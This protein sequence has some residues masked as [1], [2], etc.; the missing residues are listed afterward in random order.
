MEP[1]PAYAS[2]ILD[3]AIDK[4]LDYGIPNDLLLTIKQGSRVAVPLRGKIQ[5]GYVLDLKNK[6]DFLNVKPI[7]H[8]LS[9]TPLIPPDLFQ[10]ALWVSRY[11]CSPLRDV[12]RII[13]PPGVRKGMDPKEQ[14]YVMRAKTREEL[15]EICLSI[16]EKSPAQATIL[17]ALLPIKKGILLSKLLET[18]KCSR[19]SVDAL[20]KKGYL[21]LDIVRI[22]RSPLINE[23]Y[24]STKPKILNPQQAE[25]LKK[26][27][28]SIQQSVYETH[29]L[30]GITGSGK[31]EVYLQAI[32]RAL[33]ENKGTIML[34]PEIS[35]TSQTI[36][37]FKS[38]FQE[39][40]AIL[41]H[42][43][44]Q[45]ERN[46]EWHHIRSGKA[47]IVIGARSAIFSPV[48][49]LGLII[50]D[51]EHE[52]SY[53]QSEQNPC[54]QARDTAVMRGK[55]TKSTV[56]LGSATPSLESYYN[57]L[58]RKYTLSLLN[59]RAEV[60]SLPHV[61]V[62]DMKKEYEKAK[63][64]T[65]FSELLLNGI[66]KRIQKGEQTILFLNRRGYHSVLLCQD[67]QH[68]FKCQHCDLPLTFHL[69]DNCL[70][71][72]LC[73]FQ[74][75]PPPKSCPE[76]RGDKPL[77]FRGIGTEQV[78]RALHAIFPAV[79]TIR[80]DADT[81]KHKG[82][83]H[84]LLKDFGTGKAD[85]LIGTQMIA[86]GLHFSEVTLVGVLNS[87]SGLNI[88]DFR[89]SETVFQLITQVAGRSGRGSIPGEVIIQTGIPDHPTIQY[90]A[91]QDY[92]GFY[93]EEIGVRKIFN[94]P[95][96]SHLA[97]I[98]FSGKDAKQTQNVAEHFRQALVRCLPQN[99][100]FQP[101]VPCGYAKMKDNHRFQFLLKG[102]SMI[103]LNEALKKVEMNTVI[104]RVVKYF[105]DVNPSSTFF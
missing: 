47:K 74:V 84:K 72:H 78:E 92:L 89:A 1:F 22:D 37:R 23:E 43:L 28:T 34:V 65:S 4:A 66:E 94:Y 90:A 49:N 77:K 48:E 97:K 67:C 33:K 26:I 50:I 39:K 85:V 105:V 100:E 18:T 25:A 68:T 53:K 64:I 69:G 8:L 36:E 83:H 40:I 19:S 29:L 86:K 101:V 44:S 88:P 17:E 93:E 16:R 10:L 91:K 13:L 63:R 7:A 80:L 82:S 71:C 30:Y 3:V 59:Q 52:H 56:I 81:T 104:P 76:C 31:T 41:H 79:R 60:A 27:E 42:R 55:L 61:H 102:P 21:L 32:D 51:E 70:A 35:L 38:R 12:F 14:L 95:P 20:A 96:F 2:V 73:G 99:F 9:D 58:Q 98:L 75:S 46:D 24:F 103:P 5:N 87:D 57:S 45:G 15:R 6:P 62:V 11:Y 54:Y